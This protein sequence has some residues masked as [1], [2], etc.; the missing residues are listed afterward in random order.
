M[1]LAAGSKLGPYGSVGANYA[2]C[3][4]QT[5]GSP[6]VRLGEGYAANV[7]R[8][9]NWALAVVPTSPQQLVVYPTGAGETRRLERAGLVSYES[10]RFF[11]DGQRFLIR[12]DLVSRDT[13]PVTVA[14]G[15]TPGIAR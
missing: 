6:V 5:D 15:W 2:A 4:R 1:T 10:A 3:L 8:D 11:P 7:S 12:V 13:I 9:G 14:L